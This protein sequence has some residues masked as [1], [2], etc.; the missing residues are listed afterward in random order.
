VFE[1]GVKLPQTLFFGFWEPV[2]VQGFSD[3][4]LDEDGLL[5]GRLQR[6]ALF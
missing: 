6:H 3:T 1:V 2:A 5:F 4:L